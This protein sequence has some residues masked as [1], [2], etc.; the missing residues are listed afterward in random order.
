MVTSSIILTAYKYRGTEII[1]L[2][3]FVW[4]CKIFET[5]QQYTGLDSGK[6][7]NSILVI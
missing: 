6:I 3:A 2:I 7:F 1:I 4:K 5:V